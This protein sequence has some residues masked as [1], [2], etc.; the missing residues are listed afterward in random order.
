M[1]Q[2]TFSEL[3]R[4]NSIANQCAAEIRQCP[5]YFQVDEQLPFE[6]DGEGGHVFLLIE[7]KNTNTDWLAKQ[8]A[9]FAD[10]QEVAIGYAGLKDRHAVTT[11]WF[12]INME[13]KQEPDWEQFNDENWQIKQQSRHG[14]K[15]KRG[16]LKGNQFTLT[17]TNLQGEQSHWQQSLQFI[18]EQGVPNYFAE[19][20]FGHNMANLNRVE[21]WFSG[22]RSPKKRQQRSLY[23]SAA[24]SWL[25]NLVLSERIQRQNWNQ[26]LTG[27][28][29]QLQGSHSCFASEVA[30]ETL[31]LRLQT[32]DIHPTGP[33]WGRGTLASSDQTLMLE[34]RTLS[35]WQNWREGLER[36]GLKQ[37]RRALRIA[38]QKLSWDFDENRLKLSFFLPAGSYATAV[39][40][41]LASIEDVQERNL[42]QNSASQLT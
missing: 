30:D 25:F 18:Q 5:D 2:F 4:A 34:E 3:A 40:R 13:G 31:A 11:Q 7:K 35:D 10:V 33:L 8:L 37:E 17:L 32:M 19:Q 28:V 23:L 20:R 39:L 14:K 36:A 29:M 22:G 12:S 9:L 1:K 41:E 15:L 26:A 27:D 38:L 42:L 24:R 6:P 16:V 21:H